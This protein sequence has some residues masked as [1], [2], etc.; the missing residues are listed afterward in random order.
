MKA[1]GFGTQLRRTIVFA[2]RRAAAKLIRNWDSDED[3]PD[4]DGSDLEA[5]TYLR[6]GE[7]E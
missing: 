1:P 7:Y 4:G 2:V 3:G 5:A 6:V